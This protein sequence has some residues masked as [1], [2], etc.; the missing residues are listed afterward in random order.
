MAL[1]LERVLAGATKIGTV[2]TIDFYEHPV[3]GD[4]AGLVAIRGLIM[5]QTD[6]YDLPEPDDIEDPDEFLQLYS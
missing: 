3:H 5:V 6:W 4:E 1:S 2:C